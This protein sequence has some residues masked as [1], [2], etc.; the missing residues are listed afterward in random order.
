MKNQNYFDAAVVII[1]NEI[2]SGRTQDLNSNYLAKKLSLAGIKLLEVRIIPDDEKVIV[3]T[4]NLLRVKY[5]YIFTSGGIGPTHDDITAESIAK[6]FGVSL[7]INEAAVK[8]LATNYSRGA[9]DLTPA[10]LRMARVPEGAT[11]IDNPISKAP[12]FKI[13]NVFVLAGIP[14]IFQGMVRSLLPTLNGGDPILSVSVIISK[15]ES[16]IAEDLTKIAEKFED[17]SIG[18]Y[19]FEENGLLGTNIIAM[20]QDKALLQN[21]I[22]LLK[23][24]A[25]TTP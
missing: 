11:L 4:V 5:S 1:G 21:V 25:K 7:K 6:A 10:R 16:E 12:G 9:L 20:H 13:D 8:I 18:S 22:K 3:S 23:T 14:K 24:L 17:V 15:V 19:P 2:L